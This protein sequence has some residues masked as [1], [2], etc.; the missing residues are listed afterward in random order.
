MF[1]YKI[2]VAT[3]RNSIFCT[4]QQFGVLLCVLFYTI[5]T[6]SRQMRQ[7]FLSI[8]LLCSISLVYS[9][10]LHLPL[11]NIKII[12]LMIILWIYRRRSNSHSTPVFWH[13][14]FARPSH[15]KWSLQRWRWRHRWN[16]SMMDS[17]MYGHIPRRKCILSVIEKEREMEI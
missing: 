7:S 5:Q 9:R 10:M 11:S 3:T 6:L 2:A 16:S 4:I 15:Q 8:R 17:L 1:S 13:L 14:V 12:I